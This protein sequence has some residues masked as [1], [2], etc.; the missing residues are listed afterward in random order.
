MV[1][2][3]E[4]GKKETKTPKTLDMLTPPSVGMPKLA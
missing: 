1:V 2:Y 4:I 3:K